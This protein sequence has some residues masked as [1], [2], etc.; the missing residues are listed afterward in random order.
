M[1]DVHSSTSV[2]IVEMCIY[3]IMIIMMIML[4]PFTQPIIYSA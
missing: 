3:V 2:L 1:N 4:L